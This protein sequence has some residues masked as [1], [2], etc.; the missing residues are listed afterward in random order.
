MTHGYLLEGNALHAR[1]SHPN[2]TGSKLLT[3]RP[4]S[5][6]SQKALLP[7]LGAVKIGALVGMRINS[8]PMA[9]SF[10]LIER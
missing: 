9:M 2:R 7:L 10:R 5:W 6:K 3:G 4:K 1:D 8:S